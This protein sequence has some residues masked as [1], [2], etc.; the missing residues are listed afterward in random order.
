MTI[1]GFYIPVWIIRS[2]PTSGFLADK[3]YG[4]CFSLLR[5][6]LL[7]PERKDSGWRTETTPK[8]F[9]TFKEEKGNVFAMFSK[10]QQSWHVPSV[11]WCP[12]VCF[13]TDLFLI[14]YPQCLHDPSTLR[15]A[16]VYHQACSTEKREFKVHVPII[17]V[18]LTANHSWCVYLHINFNVMHS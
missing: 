8:T 18:F 17:S 12:R 10:I 4:V 15:H 2:R 3:S 11:S 7:A 5:I 1:W 6:F 13:Q 16:E 9:G 14:V